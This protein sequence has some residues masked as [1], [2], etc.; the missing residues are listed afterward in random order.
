MNARRTPQ[1]VGQ[2]HLSDQATDLH[3]NLWPTATRARLPTPVQP[4]TRPIP[5]NDSVWLD[6]R[7][8]DGNSRYSQTK[9]SRS[10]IGLG[11]LGQAFAWLLAALPY[12]QRADVELVLQDFD[13]VGESNDST[14]ILSS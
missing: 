10:V 14:S 6:N 3:S 11:N 1:P 7:D 8:I 12:Q 4:D 2:A 5:P 9:S 13:V